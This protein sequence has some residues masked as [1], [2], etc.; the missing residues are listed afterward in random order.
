MPPIAVNWTSAGFPHHSQRLP[1]GTESMETGR[2]NSFSNIK[3]SSSVR[4]AQV[5]LFLHKRKGETRIWWSTAV[6]NPRRY[7]KYKNAHHRPGA[8]SLLCSTK[9]RSGV[10]CRYRCNIAHFYEKS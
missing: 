1:R 9:R 8:A 6:E 2:L 7:G 10:F 3:V 5:Q 4:T